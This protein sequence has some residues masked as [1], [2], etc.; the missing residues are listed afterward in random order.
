LRCAALLQHHC[1]CSRLLQPHCCCSAPLQPHC[2][3]S[4]LLQTHRCCSTL[5]QPRCCCSNCISTVSKCYIDNCTSLLYM[6]TIE[7]LHIPG[8]PLANGSC[9]QSNIPLIVHHACPTPLMDIYTPGY[10]MAL[11]TGCCSPLQPDC[12]CHLILPQLT[13]A[14]N[15][16]TSS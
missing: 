6:G 14:P 13:N 5:L 12:C 7:S 15:S 4:E 9:M 2:C 3:C 1:C 8:L 10:T 11:H 16:T